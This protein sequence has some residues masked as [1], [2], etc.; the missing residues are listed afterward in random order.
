MSLTPQASRRLALVLAQRAPLTLHR[1]LEDL[2][3]RE[4]G[5]AHARG[6]AEAERVLLGRLRILHVFDPSTPEETP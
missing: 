4:S 2:A 5:A 6:F 1:D 3:Q